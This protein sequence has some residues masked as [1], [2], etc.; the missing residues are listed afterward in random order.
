MTRNAFA[1]LAAAVFCLVAP[2]LFAASY[3]VPPDRDFIASAPA[4]VTGTVIGSR[5]EHGTY[6][7]ETITTL[8]VEEVLKGSILQTN[9][10]IHEPGGTLDGVSRVIP[11]TPEFDAGEHV[12]LML[13]TRPDGAWGIS[14]LGLGRF[15]FERDVAGHDVLIR[16]DVEES[17][18]IQ[19]RRERTVRANR[20][21][22]PFLDYIRA[23]VRGVDAA[24]DYR[25]PAASLEAPRP[26][27]HRATVFAT[28]I[29]YT[30]N[31]GERWCT[32]LITGCTSGTTFPITYNR[33]GGTEP[34]A[35]GGGDT[36]ITTALSAWSNIANVGISIS[37]GG[38]AGGTDTGLNSGSGDNKSGIQFE[39]DL[40]WV[41]IPAFT[42]TPSSYNGTL[43]IGGFFTTNSHLGPGG[44]TF[45]TIKEGDVEM[46]QG[47]ANCTLLL[48]TGDWKTAVTH[49]VGHTLGFRHADL[50]RSNSASCDTNPN[51]D[52]SSNAIMTAQ[53]IHSINATPQTWDISAAQAVYGSCNA[54][55]INTNPAS[56]S[57]NYGASTT[58][59][60]V[61]SNASG[62]QWYTGSSGNTSSPI[63]GATSSSVQVSPTSTTSYWVQVTGCSGSPQNSTAATVTVNCG[64]FISSQP[65]G[66]SIAL[67]QSRQLSVTASGQPPF[68]YQWYVGT[69]P[70]T[71]NPI[72]GATNSTVTV[73]PTTT[74]N[75]WVKVTGCSSNTVNSTTVT[76]TV[77]CKP[78]IT[79]QPLDKVITA[80][81]TANLAVTATNATSYQWYIG[82]SGNTFTPIN[83]ATTSSVNVNPT[84]TTTYWV[85]VTNSCGDRDSVTVTVTV[86]AVACPP[87]VVGTPT[88]TPGANNQYTF[89]VT[90]T[91]GTSFTF[92]WFQSTL[93]GPVQVGTGQSIVLT[94]ASASQYYVH[95]LNNCGN[96][97]DS[98]VLTVGGPACTNPLVTQ[99][100]NVTTTELSNVTLT[101]SASSTSGALHYA[102][103]RGN[104]PDT[105]QHIGGDSASVTV[106]VS[107]TTTFWV[108]VTNDCG[109]TSST[110]ITVTALGGKRRAGRHF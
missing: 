58:L 44:D 38:A 65:V 50:T 68:T 4:I 8:A 43:G 94:V 77:D 46:N 105:T 37:F 76:V 24:E 36:A 18:T 2:S 64:P 40:T 85:R 26:A 34:G 72:G 11:G 109:S 110:A 54:A 17:Q 32:T 28:P 89:N 71:S 108:K 57:I 27:G 90:A 73:S 31:P 35:P 3:I 101:V 51:L 82:N 84:V 10:E 70:D 23:N 80:G 106:T 33:Y 107:T 42:C 103:Y 39:R 99:P 92:T 79:G 52:C 78:V 100:A 87:V 91:G 25:I 97:A 41:P 14:D 22:A 59:T 63:N 12:L 104:P 55:S 29:T 1:A 30:Y 6:G 5:V 86:S 16:T 19:V 88:A 61:A 15:S 13:R 75:Y 96:S 45:Q 98:I 67:G 21:A 20:E 66:G 69:A 93:G 47:I 74:T 81:G 62:Y 83:G 53:L 56:V 9:L 49:E 7:I 48:S 95:V 102:W 60:V